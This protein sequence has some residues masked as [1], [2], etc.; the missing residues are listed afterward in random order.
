[1]TRSFLRFA[2]AAAAAATLTF[3]LVTPPADGQP[4]GNQALQGAQQLKQYPEVKEALQ[5]L[6]DNDKAG[7]AEK[8]EQAAGKYP[9]LPSAHVVLYELLA[10]ANRTKEALAELD[11]AVKANPSDPEPYIILGSIALRKRNYDEAKTEFQNAEKLFGKYTNKA[12]KSAIE[13]WMLS[14]MASLAELQAD[15]KQADVRLRRMLTLA[16]EDLIAHQRL[17]RA[18]FL[19]GKTTEAFDLLKKGKAI[20]LRNS[21]KLGVGEQ[22]P[23]PEVIMARFYD[24]LE[25]PKSKTGNAEKWFKI[26][27]EKAPGDMKVRV[28]AANWSL[29]RGK[30]AMAK[31][32]ARIDLK[33]QPKWAHRRDL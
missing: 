13:P 12:R 3:G 28:E 26:A 2:V 7:A 27:M 30:I 8:L 9:E 25:G 23:I 6:A 24:E 33:L 22:M 32:F 15:W 16:P 31:V 21:K 5:L 18:L 14:G 4:A 1:M 19:Q 20:D 10:R 17:A 29:R 11:E